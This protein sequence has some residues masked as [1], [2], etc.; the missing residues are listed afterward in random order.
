MPWGNLANNQMVSYTDA[1]GGG[2]T[3]KSGQSSV[4]SPQC[5]TKL[6]ALTKYNLNATN[7][8]A[9]TDSQLVPKSAWSTNQQSGTL[10]IVYINSFADRTWSNI[11]NAALVYNPPI[12]A[13]GAD[14]PPLNGPANTQAI[15]S[16]AG[17]ISSAASVCDNLVGGGFSDWYL[18]GWGENLGLF[19]NRT[20]VNS[21]ITANGGNIIPSTG[22]YWSSTPDTSSTITVFVKDL[23]NGSNTG[24]FS[25][26]ATAGFRAIR[27][28]AVADINAYSIGQFIF[29]GVIFDKF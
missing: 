2:F 6:D 20:V 17:H 27:R 21:G 26:S 29:G 28:Q 11:T 24:N 8:S 23:A 5:M 16:Q 25:K 14:G 13:I 7:M 10:R 3:L 1:Q 19:N 9:Y 4:T 18:G 15:I 12:P 22:F